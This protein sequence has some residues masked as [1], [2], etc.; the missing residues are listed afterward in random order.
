VSG[1]RPPTG[2][3]RLQPPP[4]VASQEAPTPSRSLRGAAVVADPLVGE[5]LEACLVGLLATLEPDGSVHAIPIWYARDGDAIVFATGSRSHKVRNL[6]R[7]P[8]ATF[9]VHDSRPGA[10]VCGA[11]IRGVVELVEGAAA[12]PLVELVHRRYVTPA[13]KRLPAT[14]VHL[15]VDDVVIR[16]L[17]ATAFT[18]DERASLAARELREAGAALPLEP[19]SPR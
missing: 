9:V 18:W 1:E 19:T 11:S 17:P 12:T 10:E 6:R 16:L 7:D 5:L 4:G 8:R 2:G 15:G 14:A 3:A 13:G